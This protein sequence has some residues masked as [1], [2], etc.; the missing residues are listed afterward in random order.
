MKKNFGGV[1]LLLSTLLICLLYLSFTYAKPVRESAPLSTVSAVGFTLF[2]PAYDSL[3]T[4]LPGL[5]REAFE[6]AI[7]GYHKLIAEGRLNNQSI[8]SIAD[9]SQSSR[10]KRLYIIDLA[11][12][13]VL[14]NT[15]VAHGRNSG[16]EMATNFSNQLASY[17]S[18]PGFY[19]TKGTYVGSHGYSLK[20]DGIEKGINDNANNRA[21]VMHGADY[22]NPIT[23]KVLGFL[24]RSQG[25]PAVPA[26][27]SI[28]IIKTIK[29]GTCL[30]IYHPSYVKRSALLG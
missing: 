12:S 14:F 3:Q 17:K 18:S 28:P 16:G 1:Y 27:L 7:K 2:S 20:L 24:G 29:D 26:Q 22:V 21:I 30:F 25:C 4:E 15:W 23:F 13:K 11:Q 19:I 6:Y 9:F 8:I 5:S 10:N